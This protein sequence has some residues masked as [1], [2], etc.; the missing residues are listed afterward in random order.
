MNKNTKEKNI[1]ELISLLSRTDDTSS[2]FEALVDEDNLEDRFEYFTDALSSLAS[3]LSAYKLRAGGQLGGVSVHKMNREDSQ[4]FEITSTEYNL[5][6]LLKK[7]ERFDESV[8]QL[9]DAKEQLKLAI[10]EKEKLTSHSSE[11]EVP[12]PFH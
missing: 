5:E 8:S 10:L 11:E 12:T 4:T 3:I 6:N 2:V 9:L 7:F 1:K